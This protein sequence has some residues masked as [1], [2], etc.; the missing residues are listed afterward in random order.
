MIRCDASSERYPVFES[1]RESSKG[2]NYPIWLSSPEG[3]HRKLSS[4]LQTPVSMTE[5]L[6]LHEYHLHSVEQYML[7]KSNTCP[8]AD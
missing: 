2:L 3:D 6:L 5:M 4:D 7:L 1:V 8:N